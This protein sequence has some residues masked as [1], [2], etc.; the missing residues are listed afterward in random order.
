MVRKGS[1]FEE[2][3]QEDLF[4]LEKGK[5]LTESKIREVEP[6]FEFRHGAV[7][8]EKE[9]PNQ[10][11]LFYR[12]AASVILV[13][14]ASV[15]AWFYLNPSSGEKQSHEIAA[16]ETTYGQTNSLKLPDGSSIVLNNVTSIQFPE[17]Y[18]AS[19]RVVSL[20]GEALFDV[21][22]DSLHPFI[23]KMG[24]FETEV[25]GTKFNVK[26]YSE[27]KEITVSLI[28]GIVRMKW[29]DKE[30]VRRSR[31]IK[32]N[33]QLIYNKK[34]R[35]VEVNGFKQETVVSWK[36]EK[37]IFNGD[38]L[39]DVLPYLSRKYGVEFD[40]RN[41]QINDCLIKAQFED[42]SLNTILQ[43]I[44]FANGIEYDIKDRMVTLQGPGCH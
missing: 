22:S 8:N 44:S 16:V 28:E 38:P 37:F 2:S 25:L 27:D 20:S 32:A 1:V 15:A 35:Q 13:I 10:R 11:K 29:T 34:S 31:S 9:A 26:A 4:D 14:S 18:T 12:I 21:E 40:I 17:G 5:K 7:H 6:D 3:D 33:E 30:G 39:S 36:D 41:E 43:V 19:N 23:V 42:E 24:D